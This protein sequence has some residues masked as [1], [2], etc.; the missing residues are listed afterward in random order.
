M[1]L[2]HDA[3]LIRMVNQIAANL[4]GGRDEASAVAAIRRH[5]ETF[6][7]RPMKQRLIAGLEREG[8]ELLPLARQATQQLAERLSEPA[9]ATEPGA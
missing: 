7:A 3:Q 9:S 8:S 4:G 5:L 1:S 6:W 2:H